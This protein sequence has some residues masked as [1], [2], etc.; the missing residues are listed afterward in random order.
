[1]IWIVLVAVLVDEGLIGIDCKAEV[2]GEEPTGV[3]MWPA[4]GPTR[5]VHDVE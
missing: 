4:G 3:L 1:M 5:V 2:D